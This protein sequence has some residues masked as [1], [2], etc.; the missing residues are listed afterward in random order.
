MHISS[1]FTVKF[2]WFIMH[3]KPKRSPVPISSHPLFPQPTLPL[4]LW[5]SLIYFPS[6][7]ICLFWPFHK[8]EIPPTVAFCDWFLHSAACCEGSPVRQ[9][10][11]VR[12]SFS[13]R[14]MCCVDTSYFIY[15]S[16]P[17]WMLALILNDGSAVT[18]SRR[19][20]CQWSEC[21]MFMFV[22]LFVYECSFVCLWMFLSLFATPVSHCVARDIPFISPFLQLGNWL[23]IVWPALSWPFLVSF[24]HLHTIYVIVYGE[25]HKGSGK[26]I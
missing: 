10:L 11:S 21:F 19:P 4:S 15:P 9:P 8:N 16:T 18:S 12:P 2:L 13:P 25:R 3:L 5:Q 20:F 7:W 14:V 23:S 22:P 17:W 1:Q 24:A 6:L 26:N